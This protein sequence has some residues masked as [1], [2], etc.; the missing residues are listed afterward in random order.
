[1]VTAFLYGC[2]LAFI[3]SQLV[4]TTTLHKYCW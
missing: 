2:Y 4:Q 1:L 3:A